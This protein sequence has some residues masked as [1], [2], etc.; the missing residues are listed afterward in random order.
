MSN[1]G[2]GYFGGAALG[3]LTSG[4][5]QYGGTG[6]AGGT[7]T[8]GDLNIPGGPG[9]AAQLNNTGNIITGVGGGSEMAQPS[10]Y[11]AG[12]NANGQPGT[13]YGGGGGGGSQVNNGGAHSGGN[14]AAGAVVILEIY[15]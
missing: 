9:G 8:G 2:R 5:P 4:F 7:P 12:S 15:Q 11:F 10:S 14:G 3:A 6:G 13:G 1:A